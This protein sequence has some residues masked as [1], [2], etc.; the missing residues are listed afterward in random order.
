VAAV[1]L[2]TSVT[3]SLQ[4]SHAQATAERGARVAPEQAT[5]ATPPE[6]VVP[7][8]AP[9]TPV[10]EP[11]PIAKRPAPVV[12]RVTP[13]PQRAPRQLISS[14]ASLNV[15]ATGGTVQVWVDG[16]LR[17]HS[18]LR[19]DVAAGPHQVKLL[20]LSSGDSSEERITFIAGVEKSM[21]VNLGD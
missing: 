14:V 2:L 13:E 17:G 19:V 21:Q 3:L 4:N 10:P 1:L 16:E 8:E 15:R 11:A 20:D 12:A 18:P 7:V 6:P 5:A 9:P